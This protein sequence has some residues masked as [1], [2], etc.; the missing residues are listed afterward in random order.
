MRQRIFAAGLA[1][2][3][4]A[5]ASPAAWS[6][7]GVGVC[8]VGNGVEVS[9]PEGQPFI[10]INIGASSETNVFDEEAAFETQCCAELGRPPD[11]FAGL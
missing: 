9:T 11:C 5:F 1:V 4:I 6:A 7:G 3:T 8:V 10:G 2:M